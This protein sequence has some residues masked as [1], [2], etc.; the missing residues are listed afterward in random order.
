MRA[1][2]S[3][4]GTGFKRPGRQGQKEIDCRTCSALAPALSSVRT[5]PMTSASRIT[6]HIP[7]DANTTKEP[8]SQRSGSLTCGFEIIPP[9]FTCVDI[10]H[11]TRLS[12]G[13]GKRESDYRAPGRTLLLMK[14]SPSARVTAMPSKRD[15]VADTLWPS[16]L[17]RATSDAV[18]N[19][20]EHVSALALSS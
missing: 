5:R 7:S 19:R 16:R 6:S 9:G 18:L 17:R 3:T 10:E 20:C 2:F 11:R 14:W 13:V 1:R 12:W 15:C 4:V 8:A